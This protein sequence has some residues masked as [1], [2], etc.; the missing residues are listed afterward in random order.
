MCAIWYRSKLTVISQGNCWVLVEVCTLLSG[1]LLLLLLLLCFIMFFEKGL[2][3]KM[4]KHMIIRWVSLSQLCFMFVQCPN[5]LF[6]VSA[7]PSKPPISWGHHGF[8][9]SGWQWVVA[10]TEHAQCAGG[11]EL[12][13]PASATEHGRGG[14]Q[15]GEKP[16]WWRPWPLSFLFYL[17]QHLFQQ[18]GTITLSV[19]SALLWK[20]ISYKLFMIIH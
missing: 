12:P 15:W 3:K 20:Q 18:T 10:V 6:F 19:T 7:S 4:L 5:K 9:L 1:I 14:L 16:R 13:V 8:V 11:T 2:K 17:S